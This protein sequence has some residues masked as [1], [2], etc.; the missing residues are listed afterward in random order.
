MKAFGLGKTAPLLL[1]LS[2]FASCGYHHD[3]DASDEASSPVAFKPSSVNAVELSFSNVYSKVLAP[4]CLK[5]HSGADAESG[6]RFDTYG[7]T[8]ANLADVQRAVFTDHSMPKNSSLSQ[9]QMNLLWAWIQAN[10]PNDSPVATAVPLPST[11][12]APIHIVPETPRP[13]ARPTPAPRSNVPDRYRWPAIQK[14]VFN[15]SCMPCHSSSRKAR[16][17]D[18]SNVANIRQHVDAVIHRVLVK[19]DMPP[20]SR[21]ALTQDQIDALVQWLRYGMQN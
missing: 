4:K 9:S 11:T 15:Q 5:C 2:L 14:L 17:I 18:V 21:S 6:V 19:R 10:A 16:G 13:S 20:R 1:I 8:V 3:K 7:D 12:P